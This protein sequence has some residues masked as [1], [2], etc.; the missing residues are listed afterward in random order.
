MENIVYS[1]DTH[2]VAAILDISN[3]SR[4]PRWQ[5]ASSELVDHLSFVN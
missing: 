4:L 5:H 3:P 1:V 2:K